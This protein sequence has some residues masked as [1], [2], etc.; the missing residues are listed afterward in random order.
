MTLTIDEMWVI[1]QLMRERGK[2]DWPVSVAFSSKGETVL[3]D[4]VS[5]DENGKTLQLNEEEFDARARR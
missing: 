2:G 4:I 3:S 5:V 1:C